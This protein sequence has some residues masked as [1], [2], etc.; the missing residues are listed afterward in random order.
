MLEV[1]VPRVPGTGRKSAHVIADLD[2]VPE[3]VVGVVSVRFSAVIALER[4]HRFHAH[5]EL[6]A[7]GQG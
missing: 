4:G 7:A 3:L 1:T 2:Q 6:P 5:G